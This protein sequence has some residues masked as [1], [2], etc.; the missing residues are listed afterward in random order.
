MQ[1]KANKQKQ[2]SMKVFRIKKNFRN[3]QNYKLV[4]YYLQLDIK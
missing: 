2:H 4:F 3:Y 1:T